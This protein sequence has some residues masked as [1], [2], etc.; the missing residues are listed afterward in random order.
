MAR[1]NTNGVASLRIGNRY[2]SYRGLELSFMV[3]VRLWIL[4]LSHFA[5]LVVLG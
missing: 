2:P 5:M 4:G 1:L 3:F